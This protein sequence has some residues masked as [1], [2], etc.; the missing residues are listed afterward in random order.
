VRSQL[1]RHG[2]ETQGGSPEAY[3]ALL[4]TEIAKW[5]AVIRESG[6]RVD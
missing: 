1:A 2:V 6:A 5:A 4:K 3:G